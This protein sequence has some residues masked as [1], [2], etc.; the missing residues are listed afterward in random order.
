LILGCQNFNHGNKQEKMKENDPRNWNEEK[1]WES[2]LDPNFNFHPVLNADIFE[3]WENK[4]GVSKKQ[5]VEMKKAQ[6]ALEIDNWNNYAVNNYAI[7]N[8]EHLE[9][10]LKRSNINP[11]QKKVAKIL[12]DRLKARINRKKYNAA[13]WFVTSKAI[14]NGDIDPENLEGNE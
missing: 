6:V 5:Y 3:C 12:R 1:V 11:M 4:I 7:E 14:L 2:I 9:D 10:I 8:F 13:G